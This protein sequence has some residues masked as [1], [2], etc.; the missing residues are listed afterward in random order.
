MTPEQF[1]KEVAMVSAIISDTVLQKLYPEVQK[2][3]QGYIS[4]VELIGDWAIEFAEKHKDTNWEDAL[5]N[6]IKPLTKFLPEIICWDDA[7]MDFAVHKFEEYI[8]NQ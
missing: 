1:I 7:V 8:K 5:E 2:N 3:G 6:G 4:T